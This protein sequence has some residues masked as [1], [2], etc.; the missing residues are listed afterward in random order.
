M[1]V[2]CVLAMAFAIGVDPRRLA[3]L[4]GAIY[5]P[6]VFA[7]LLAVHWYRARGHETSQP[8]LFCEGVSAELRAGATLRDALIS[9]AA[10]VGSDP[11]PIRS[12]ATEIAAT[13][14]ELFPIIGQELRL[15][16]LAA[17]R[18]G[19]DSAALFDEIGSLA[20]AQSE[21]RREVRMATAPG[22]ATALLLVG[23]PLFY[24]VVR[25]GSGGVSGFLAS[26]EQRF[27]A[28]LGLGLFLLGLVAACIIL[29]RATPWRA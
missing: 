3:L 19:S 6:V 16:V 22:L 9:A 11:I 24:L 27:V 8:S 20:I 26:A 7:G 14:G 1:I 4:A 21:I 5:L 13:V 29:W 23:A 17:V 10:S 18:A 25:L 2:A 15:T 12:S 28:V